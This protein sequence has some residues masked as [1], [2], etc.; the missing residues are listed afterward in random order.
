[1]EVNQK[2][3][4]SRDRKEKLPL[5]KTELQKG[6]ESGTYTEETLA[7]AKGM[8]NWLPLSDPYWEKYG[9][10]VDSCMPPELPPLEVPEPKPPQEE[11][12]VVAQ[13][14]LDWKGEVAF[15][16]GL[17]FTGIGVDYHENGQKKQEAH[18][19]DG[20]GHGPAS[21]WYQSGQKSFE[22][23]YKEGRLITDIGWQPNGDV[24]PFTN[25]VNGNGTVVTWHENGQKN[26]ECHY[27]DGQE[28]GIVVFWNESGLKTVEVN[29]DYGNKGEELHTIFREDGSKAEEG[30]WK[31]EKR[32]G[33]WVTFSEDGKAD[34]EIHYINGQSHFKYIT[35]YENGEIK[36]EK[37]VK[38]G[39][40]P[41]FTRYH[42]NGQKEGA[43]FL[44]QDGEKEG[45]W[46]Y[47]Y[48]NGQKEQAE[49]CLRGE[50]QIIKQWDEKGRLVSQNNNQGGNLMQKAAWMQRQTQIN[51]MNEFFGE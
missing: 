51:Q 26:S 24:C 14:K 12:K 27:Q 16:E 47:W 7:W 28:C 32:F 6:L 41:F 4:V 8:P 48:K 30:C 23:T 25:V 40:N 31:D 22:A 18:Y 21:F 45:L 36:N 33:I 43:G 49:E 20:K 44:N 9:I 46:T 13:E 19:K 50:C 5:D 17:P 15:Y 35:R 34:G 42:D 11:L 2:F 38:D 37:E 10:I 3:F 29:T 39:E 1:M